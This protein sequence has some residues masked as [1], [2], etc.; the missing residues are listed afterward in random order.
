MDVVGHEY[1]HAITRNTAN[2]QYLG[3]SG[4]LNEAISD[5]FGAALERN[6]LPNDW[7]WRLSE[8]AFTFRNMANPAEA[9]PPITPYGQPDQYLGPRWIDTNQT[10]TGGLEPCTPGGNDGNGVH[11]NSGVMN[12]WFHTL[13]TG[14][15]PH[16]NWTQAI[17]FDNAT[18]IVFRALQYYLHSTANYLDAREATLIA[19]QDLFG[20]CSNEA[21]QVINAWGRPM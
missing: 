20:S 2:L 9:F 17:D 12:K 8:D 4:A 10:P 1:M 13:C 16:S 7:N 15:N 19:A 5:I 14:Q 3:Q 6:V 21:Q 18:R 11:I